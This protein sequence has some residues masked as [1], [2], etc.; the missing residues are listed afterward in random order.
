MEDVA[1]TKR[2]ADAVCASATVKFSGPTAVPALV[3][4]F[5]TLEIAGAVLGAAPIVSTKVR[6]PAPLALVALIET[7]EV[8]AAVGVPLITPV[9]VFTDNPAGKPAALKLVGELVAVIV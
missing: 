4:W 1:V 2:L 9:E 5:A 3:V 8:A 6:E 7:F